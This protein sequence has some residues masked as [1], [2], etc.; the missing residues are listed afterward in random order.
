MT[1]A[2]VEHAQPRDTFVRPSADALIRCEGLEK[3]YGGVHALKGVDFHAERAEVVGLVGDNGAGKSTLIK[4]LSG[5]HQPDSGRIFVEGK[6]VRLALA[7]G[8][9]EPGRRDDLPVHG[10]GP[11]NV[12]R[13]E[14]LHR[15]RAAEPLADRRHRP[16]GQRA[17]WPS[18]PSSR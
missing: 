1:E 14:H 2:L 9:D 4:L 10:D 16:D 17:R 13:P 6:E 8:G 15:P 3:W 18:T 12:H 7:Q 11:A 5:A